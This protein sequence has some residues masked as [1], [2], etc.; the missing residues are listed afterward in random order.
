M[1]RPLYTLLL[2]LALPF[3]LPHLFWRA[4]REPG[5]L[6]GF[7]TRFGCGPALP[8]DGNLWIHAASVGE[9]Q[10]AGVLIQALRAALPERAI[11]LTCGTAT[12]RARARALCDPSVSVRYAPFDLP[13]SLARAFARLRPAVLIVL[14]VEIWPNLLAGCAR[15][16]V[17]VVFASARLSERSASSWARWPVL[18]AGSLAR[19]V[20][21]AAQSP[22]DAARFVHLGVPATAVSVVGNLKFDRAPLPDVA[23]RGA[24]IRARYAPGQSFWVA[25]S[26]REGEEAIVLEAARAVA[27]GC[28]GAVL[29]L[30]PRHPPRFAELAETIVAAGFTCIRHSAGTTAGSGPQIVLV[31]TLGELVDFYAAA[32]VAFVGGSLVPLG[33][34]NLLEPAMLGVPV[35]AGPHQSNAPDIARVLEEA[36]ALR[37]VADAA[38]LAA[39]VIGMLGDPGLRSRVGAAG[40]DAIAA[41]RGALEQILETVRSVLR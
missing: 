9:A 27:V 25:G 13:G 20:H 22:A 34:H 12:G 37:I 36:A 11:V 8:D 23:V 3:V 41:N 26:T 33:G 18:L 17:P 31:D 38:G 1:V 40:R 30:A 2:Y 39:A 7:G 32:D 6:R 14:E 10:A 24:G 19:G 21:V 28:P 5:A 35:I 29:A 4:W 16:G 15:R